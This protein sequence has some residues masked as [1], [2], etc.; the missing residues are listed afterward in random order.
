MTA[1][2]WCLIVT[3]FFPS[4]ARLLRRYQWHSERCNAIE[5][6]GGAPVVARRTQQCVRES[7][8]RS[9]VTMTSRMAYRQKNAATGGDFAQ[10]NITDVIGATTRD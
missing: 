5:C 6:C 3:W 4:P 10:A 8:R 7:K 1:Q 9:S 2:P